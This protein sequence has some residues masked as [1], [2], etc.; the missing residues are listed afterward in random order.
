MKNVSRPEQHEASPSRK[1]TVDDYIHVEV[2]ETVLQGPAWS[3]V[4]LEGQTMRNPH[5]EATRTN[6][7]F[8][9]LARNREESPI[10]PLANGK[11]ECEIFEV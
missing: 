3:N 9:R 7:Q 5:P 4:A 2:E 10:K 1:E 8:S 6:F 11:V